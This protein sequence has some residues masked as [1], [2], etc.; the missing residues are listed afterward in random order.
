MDQNL[1]Q[2]WWPLPQWLQEEQIYCWPWSREHVWWKRDCCTWLLLRCPCRCYFEKHRQRLLWPWA[3]EVCKKSGS[4]ELKVKVSIDDLD[5]GSYK[6]CHDPFYKGDVSSSIVCSAWLRMHW[7]FKRND[8]QRRQ[9]R[10]WCMNKVS[11]LHDIDGR[12]S[13]GWSI[14]SVL[15]YLKTDYRSHCTKPS[16][17]WPIYTM[18]YKH[19][20]KWGTL[21]T[22]SASKN[23]RNRKMNPAWSSKWKPK[24]Y[25]LWL[26][27]REMKT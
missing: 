24:S 10:T 3:W 19:P 7:F 4:G 14:D 16:R 18:Y 23:P 12:H 9:V 20:E 17:R 22:L 8:S 27:W 26:E 6:D 2:A 15:W 1:Q 5:G 25:S 13:M 21:F 11:A